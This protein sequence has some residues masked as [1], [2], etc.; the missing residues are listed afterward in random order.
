MSRGAARGALVALIALV[1]TR[2][3]IATTCH[4]APSVA[5]DRRAAPSST[6]LTFATWNAK[7]LF[8]GV[9]DV[10]ASP[11]AN[12][13]VTAATSHVDDVRAVLRTIDADCVVIVENETCETLARAA[14][15]SAAYASGLVDG[16]D[17]ATQQEVGM[18]SKIDFSSDFVRTENRADWDASTSS[19]AYSGSKNSGVSKHFWTRI[20]VSSR[21]VSV[22]G[23]HLKANPTQP[24]S[25]AQR[26]AQV[27]VLRAIAKAR[28]D[29][30]DAVIVAGDLNDYSDRHADAGNNSPTSKVLKR[31]RDFNDD[32]VDELEEVGGHVAQ[33]SRYTW[34][35]GSSKAKLDYIL[36]SRADVEVVSAVIRHDLV[37]SSVSDHFP[38]VAT[39]DIKQTRNTSVL[40]TPLASVSS[41]QNAVVVGIAVLALMTMFFG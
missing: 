22:I 12:G 17:S 26:E 4:A 14:N 38:L 9:G 39:L 24:S 5:S 29:A 6:T 30:G 32:G 34:Q 18:L 1:A 41:I 23:A 21:Y 3:V 20:L 40:G 35:S 7:W 13:D 11:Y 37:T 31:L 16:T 19:C 10:A 28:Y 8:D 25:C 2:G 36:T 33:A 15:A 27:E